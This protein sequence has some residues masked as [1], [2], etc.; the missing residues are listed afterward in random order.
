MCAEET[1]RTHI[2]LRINNAYSIDSLEEHPTLSWDA[3]ERYTKK[4]LTPE[5]K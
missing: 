4:D 3:A 1:Y 5:A 2:R